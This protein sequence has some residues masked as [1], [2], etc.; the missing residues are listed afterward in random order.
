MSLDSDIQLLS[1]VKLFAGFDHEQLRLLAF[2]AEART[3]E[4]G[5][6]LYYKDTLS[7]GGYVIIRG[8]IDLLSGLHESVI[9]SHGP[10][11]LIGEMALISKT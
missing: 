5:T 11:S 8:K 1:R 2:G 4:Q 6:R 9:T 7:D 3:V 10:S